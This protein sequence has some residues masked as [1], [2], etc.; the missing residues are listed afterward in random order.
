MLKKPF[1]LLVTFTAVISLSGCA[2]YFLRK[3]CEKTNWFQHGNKVAMDGRRLQGD[4]WM[5]QCT[6]VEAKIDWVAADLGFKAGM[7]VYCTEDGA[8]QTGLKGEFFKAGFCDV[9]GI[10]K[11]K[12]RHKEGVAELCQLSNGHEKG[13]SGWKYNGICPKTL[14][15]GFLS[16]YRP[17]RI[18]YLS[19]LIEQKRAA[20]AGLSYQISDS[21]EEIRRANSQLRS[22]SYR[23][24]NSQSSSKKKKSYK[25]NGSSSGTTVTSND[26]DYDPVAE[27]RSRL[28]STISSA[29][30]SIRSYRDEQNSLRQEIATLQSEQRSLRAQGNIPEG[31]FQ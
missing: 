13:A 15:K 6:Q 12:A 5:H 17:G 3:N 1:F 7:K 18:I 20:I 28:N 2:S 10:K 8:Y 29:R 4:D 26:S 14:A 19:G 16:T 31:S 21:E 25:F 9:G 11:I 30:R 23:R 24:S 22:L 27:E